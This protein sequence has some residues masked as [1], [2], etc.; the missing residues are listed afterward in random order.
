MIICSFPGKNLQY[1]KIHARLARCSKKSK[2]QG[3]KKHHEA[4]I[5]KGKRAKN[6]PYSNLHSRKKEGKNYLFLPSRHKKKA[7]QKALPKHFFTLFYIFI[8]ILQPYLPPPFWSFQCN[9]KETNSW[10]NSPGGVFALSSP[11]D[12]ASISL[13]FAIICRVFFAE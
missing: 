5:F 12:F 10:S 9:I 4:S 11:F 3:V 7:F 6:I 8:S 1:F 2:S 13:S